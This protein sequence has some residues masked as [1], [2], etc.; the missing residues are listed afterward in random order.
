MAEKS[1]PATV[2][3]QLAE[4]EESE[5]GKKSIKKLTGWNVFFRA[6]AVSNYETT[7]DI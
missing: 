2:P 1:G 4:G 3:A 5:P 7:S 6:V